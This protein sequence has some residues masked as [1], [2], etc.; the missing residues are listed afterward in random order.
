[1]AGI[2]LTGSS[3]G[4]GAAIREQLEARNVRVIGHGTLAH[5]EQT[6]GANLA[7]DAGPVE[8]GA[9]VGQGGWR[10][11]QLGQHGLPGCVRGHRQGRRLV[12]TPRQH[13]SVTLLHVPP[14]SARM[15]NNET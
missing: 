4:I 7:E 9:G 1:M 2:L 3:R 6:V 8:P 13:Q 14:V 10:Q 11:G 15:T 12:R 5:D